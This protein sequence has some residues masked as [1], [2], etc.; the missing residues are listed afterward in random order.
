ML[1][2]LR[3]GV[4]FLREEV[5]T[6]A[7][8]ESASSARGKVVT[9][10][11]SFMS[12]CHCLCDFGP[13][14]VLLREEV[15]LSPHTPEAITELRKKRKKEGRERHSHQTDVCGTSARSGI[16]CMQHGW[17]RLP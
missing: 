15:R 16:L 17:T 9:G 4:V 8:S 13:E 7:A 11:P 14:V 12:D 2:R 1:V 5:L 10:L 6:G 3:P